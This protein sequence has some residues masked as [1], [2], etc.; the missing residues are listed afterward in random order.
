M[1]LRP[2][3]IHQNDQLA[4]RLNM[5]SLRNIIYARANHDGIRGQ[6]GRGNLRQL[7]S[8]GLFV[9]CSECCV[10][11]MLNAVLQGMIGSK[12]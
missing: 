5:M 10:V 3:L 8:K 1:D 9:L 11:F 2:V 4:C 12:R 7:E 6:D